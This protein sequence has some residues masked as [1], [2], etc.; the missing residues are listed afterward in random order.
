[1]DNV[2][3]DQ[4]WQD[5]LQL[6]T[7]ILELADGS[8]LATLDHKLKKRHDCLVHFFDKYLDDIN[9]DEMTQLQ[10]MQKQ[11]HDLIETMEA[12]KEKMTEERIKQNNTGKRMR[13]Y[14]TI[15]KQK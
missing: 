1:M 14:T 6:N 3:K 10:N 9:Q 2:G 12:N 13:L 5:L 7:E 11:T 4:A 8:S 15:A